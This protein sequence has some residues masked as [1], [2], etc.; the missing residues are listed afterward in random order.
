MADAASQ[1]RQ[2]LRLV[3]RD[4]PEMREGTSTDKQLARIITELEDAL[5][6]TDRAQPVFSDGKWKGSS[7]LKR[8]KWIVSIVPADK[9]KPDEGAGGKVDGGAGA[10]T[11]GK[12][13]PKPATGTKPATSGGI[14]DRPI[15]DP[16]A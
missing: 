15:F 4:A 9:K 11:G 16:D 6:E 2:I 5:K 1:I 8:V 3:N 10:G 7:L 14:L 13:D 12:T